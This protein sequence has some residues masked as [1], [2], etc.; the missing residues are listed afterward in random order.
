MKLISFAVISF[1]AV[2]VSAQIPTRPSAAN[3]VLQPDQ[4]SI[5]EEIQ[6]LTTAYQ[7]QQEVVLKLGGLEEL[8][9]EVMKYKSVVKEFG[10]RLEKD[11]ATGVDK[12]EIREQYDTAV[13]D[14]RQA[15]DAML[16]KKE[17]I[18]E[19]TAKRDGIEVELLTLKD[20]HKLRIE[21]NVRN[22]NQIGLSPHSH[23]SKRVLVKQ[24]NEICLNADDLSAANED[25]KEGMRKVAD[26]ILGH[27]NPT[28]NILFKTWKQFMITRKKL[29]GEIGF[30][31]RHCAY[32]RELQA[33]IAWDP[34]SSPTGG[35]FQS[36]LQKFGIN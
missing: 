12:S 27:E 5:D 15:K 25:I 10:D 11:Y 1:L 7:S 16:T 8:E 24:T 28:K 17:E 20:N 9:Q 34:V 2:T 3:Y 22:Q 30:T 35:M 31:E 23:Y 32:T 18:R 26:V 13:E 33:G 19:A 36:F 4:D 29:M 21:H 6:E 14:W